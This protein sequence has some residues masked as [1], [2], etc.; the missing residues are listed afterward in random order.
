M[1]DP[2][3][4]DLVSE[5]I[6]LCS[7][8]VYK[9]NH[10]WSSAL[11]HRIDQTGAWHLHIFFTH[12]VVP[13]VNQQFIGQFI[14]QLEHM[15]ERMVDDLLVILEN[16]AYEVF[17]NGQNKLSVLFFARIARLKHAVDSVAKFFLQRTVELEI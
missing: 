17:A 1:I 14:V 4:F 3:R 15:I 12:F 8:F 16:V 10:G 6:P 2:I 11:M 9:L 7:D 13:Q 5:L